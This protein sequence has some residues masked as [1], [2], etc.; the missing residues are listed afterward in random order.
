MAETWTS[1]RQVI[2]VTADSYQYESDRGGSYQSAHRT[3]IERAGITECYLPTFDS[4]Y[5]V[6]YG[7]DPVSFDLPVIY[8]SFFRGITDRQS[9]MPGND[10]V[11]RCICKG[12]NEDGPL[13][14]QY[15]KYFNNPTMPPNFDI[16]FKIWSE[17]ELDLSSLLIAVQRN[18]TTT[19]Y[20]DKDASVTKITD[21]MWD[22]QVSPDE[23][24][25]VG[26]NVKVHVAIS[27]IIGRKV[28]KDW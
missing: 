15:P 18:S 25:A 7:E 19:I 13:I 14:L 27:D 1:S 16:S 2:V 8:K 12:I 24:T 6:C 3:Y 10:G 26:A 17:Y 4:R 20:T 23:V 22:I 21:N 28:R 9:F 11:I 5:A